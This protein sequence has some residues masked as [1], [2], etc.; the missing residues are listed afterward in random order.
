[1]VGRIKDK[2]FIQIYEKGIFR[3]FNSALI[4]KIRAMGFW[5]FVREMIG[6]Q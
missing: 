4:M 1:M 3:Y 2:L 5:A 6:L